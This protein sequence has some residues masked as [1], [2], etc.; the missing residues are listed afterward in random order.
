M[1]PFRCGC[2]SAAHLASFPKS[3]LDGA[4]PSLHSLWECVNQQFEGIYPPKETC[5]TQR[6]CSHSREPT[7]VPCFENP[8]WMMCK[9]LNRCIM[10]LALLGGLL[11]PIIVEQNQGKTLEGSHTIWACSW[12]SH[13][14]LAPLCSLWCL[15][16]WSVKKY[17][18]YIGIIGFYK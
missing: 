7:R 13:S 3:A 2:P 1:P 4:L 17:S 12:R 15:E 14:I 11:L 9:I 6:E 8:S 18:L 5:S 16:E 10:H